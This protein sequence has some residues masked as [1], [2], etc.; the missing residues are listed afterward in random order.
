MA[1]DKVNRENIMEMVVSFRRW[2]RKWHDGVGESIES[3]VLR[4]SGEFEV[5]RKKIDPS[6]GSDDKLGRWK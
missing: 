5:S 4:L 3:F 2:D 1:S 6:G